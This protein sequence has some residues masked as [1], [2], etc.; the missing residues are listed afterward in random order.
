MN[1][2]QSLCGYHHWIHPECVCWHW[3]EKRGYQYWHRD[4]VRNEF[5]SAFVCG[6]EPAL[7]FCVEGR[8]GN[9]DLHAI[10]AD[11]REKCKDERQFIAARQVESLEDYFNRWTAN[12]GMW[13]R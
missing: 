13:E 6:G 1:F 10:A 12:P 11:V 5:I 8:G 4:Y 3:A 2:K 7:Q 9:K